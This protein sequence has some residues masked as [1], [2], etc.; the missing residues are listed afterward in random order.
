MAGKVGT[1][2]TPPGNVGTGPA[3]SNR[4]LSLL[5]VLLLLRRLLHGPSFS[6]VG[7]DSVVKF[8]WGRRLDPC[9][10]H[11]QEE[12]RMNLPGTHVLLGK[13]PNLAQNFLAHE[14][15]IIFIW[16]FSVG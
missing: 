12:T 5:L 6:Y 1:G 4:S 7:N 16:E 9:K 10:V 11:C 8:V 14:S 2:P 13:I 15:I 3:L